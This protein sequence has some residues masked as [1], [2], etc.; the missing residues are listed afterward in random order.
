MKDGFSSGLENGD[1]MLTA[2]GKTVKL[3]YYYMIK[4]GD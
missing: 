4:R 2:G 1:P 3:S